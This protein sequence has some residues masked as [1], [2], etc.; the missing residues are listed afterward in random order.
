MDSWEY[1]CVIGPV[2][3]TPE[4]VRDGSFS[5]ALAGMMGHLPGAGWELLSH[6]FFSVDGAWNLS[7]VFRRR[8]TS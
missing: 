8:I 2:D 7:L 5:D 1:E 3:G 4:S 6:D